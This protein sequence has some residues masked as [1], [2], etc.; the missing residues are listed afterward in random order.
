MTRKLKL[1]WNK[2]PKKKLV[3]YRESFGNVLSVEPSER[4]RQLAAVQPMS[5]PPG[6]WDMP[7][8]HREYW[9]YKDFDIQWTVCGIMYKTYIRNKYSKRVCVKN[10]FIPKHVL[11][12]YID[13]PDKYPPIEWDKDVN[14]ETC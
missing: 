1:G 12:N 13:W 7:E 11:R 14:P 10:D 8:T 9:N 3:S 4:I 2:S 5:E 6:G